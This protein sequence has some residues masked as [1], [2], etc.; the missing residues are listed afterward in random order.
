MVRTLGMSGNTRSVE[1]SPCISR[2]TRDQLRLDGNAPRTLA[3][4]RLHATGSAV[5]GLV[6]VDGCMR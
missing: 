3:L 6:D 1:H 2:S 4:G 5:I